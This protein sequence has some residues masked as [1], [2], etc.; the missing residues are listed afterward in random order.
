MAR[1]FRVKYDGALYHVMNR[2]DRREPFFKAEADQRR[3]VE[4][5]DET[6]AKTGWKASYLHAPSKEATSNL[7]L[8]ERLRTETTM[9]VVWIAQRLSR[10]TWRYLSHLLYERRKSRQE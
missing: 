9:T 3:F 10:G 1:K 2:G 5:L 7:A 4:T 8:A 6:C